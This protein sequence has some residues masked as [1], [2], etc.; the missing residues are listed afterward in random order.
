[1]YTIY[2]GILNLKYVN[3]EVE[4]SGLA[5]LKIKYEYLNLDIRILEKQLESKPRPNVEALLH[6]KC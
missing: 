4:N 1:M 3:F 6:A 5:V 2:D